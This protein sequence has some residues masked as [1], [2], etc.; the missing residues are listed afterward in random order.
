MILRGNI[1]LAVVSVKISKKVVGKL[2]SDLL[3][4]FR[5]IPMEGSIT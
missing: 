2:Y 3:H 4:A 5:F 1:F